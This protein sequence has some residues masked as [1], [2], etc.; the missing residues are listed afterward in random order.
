MVHRL[1]GSVVFGLRYLCCSHH[2]WLHHPW[3]HHPWLHRLRSKSQYR[4]FLRI[5][6]RFRQSSP[7]LKERIVDSAE[8]GRLLRLIKADLHDAICRLRLSFWK[9]FQRLLTPI[10]LFIS[11]RQYLKC[12]VITSKQLGDSAV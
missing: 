1:C 8:S 9:P 12:D 2:P 3:L 11:Y 10:L 5:S 6:Y 4:S 7:Y